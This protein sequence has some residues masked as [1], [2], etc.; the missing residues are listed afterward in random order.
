MIHLLMF[1]YQRPLLVMVTGI[2]L[3]RSGRP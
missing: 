1:S 3:L 2:M